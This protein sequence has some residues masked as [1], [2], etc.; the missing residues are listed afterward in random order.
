ASAPMSSAIDAW[1]A[2][3]DKL[4]SRDGWLVDLFARSPELSALADQTGALLP[5]AL[6]TQSSSASGAGISFVVESGSISL[7][8]QPSVLSS[9][10]AK[11]VGGQL[12]AL[13]ASSAVDDK[14]PVGTLSLLTKGERDRVLKEF[15][16]TEIELPYSTVHELFAARVDA[17]PDAVALRFEDESLTYAKL[18]GRANRLAMTL[19]EMGAG[20]DKLLR[21]EDESLTYA[22]LDGRA[23]RLAMTLR[24]MG[25]GPDKLVGVYVER[26]VEMMVSVL[27]VMKAGAAYVPLDPGYPADRIEYMIEHAG[28]CALLV[29]GGAPARMPENAPPVLDVIGIGVKDPLKE[30]A[31]SWATPSSLAY[32]IYTSGS[33]GRPKGVM[34]EHKNAVNFF[35]GMD[36]C[37]PHETPGKWLAVTSL[38]FDI[39]VLELLWTLTRGFEV[40]LFLDLNAGDDERSDRPMDYSLFYWGSDDGEGRQKYKLLLD[41]ARFADEHDFTA[42]WTPERHFHAFGGPYPNPAVTGAAVAAVTKRLQIRSGSCVVPLHHPVR[43]AEEWAVID[44]LS[45]GR[46]ALG[47]A[48]GWQPD[49]FLL[50]PQ[51]YAEVKKRMFEILDDVRKLW[52]GEKM[53]YPGPRGDVEMMSQPR[54]VQKELP[55]WLTT[56]GNPETYRQAAEIDCHVLTHLLGQSVDE[57]AEKV[58]IYRDALEAVGKPR[59]SGKVTLMLH[60]FVGRDT[61]EVRNIV[62]QPMKDYL[63]ASISLVKSYAWAFPAFKRPAGAK[64]AFDLEL[65]GL[66]EEE[67]EAIL[68]FA[69]ERYFEDSGLF[70]DIDKCMQQVERLK[71]IEVDEI[72]CLIDFGVPTDEVLGMLPLLNQ[73]RA[74]SNEFRIARG[75]SYTVSELIEK[76]HVSHMQCT[77]SMARMLAA[78]PA[79]KS[80]LGTVENLFVGGEVFPVDLATDLKANAKGT[81][82][83]MYG[84]TETTIWS[85]TEPVQD[86]LESLPI[87][88]PIANT[89]LYVLNAQHEP[90]PPGVPGDLWIGGEGVVRG[91]LHQPDLTAE[92]FLPDPFVGGDARMYMTGDVARFLD[93]GRVDFIGR[94]DH[95][96]K[97]RGYRVELGEIESRLL[98]HDGVRS[99]AAI[100]RED[101]PGDQRLVAYVVP[102]PGKEPAEAELRAFSRERLPEYMVPQHVV[103]LSAMPQTPNKKIDRKALPA[104]SAASADFA[105]EMVVP[106][107]D[108]EQKVAEVWCHLLGRDNVGI[109]NNFFDLGGHSLLVVQ[110]SMQLQQKLERKIPLVDLYRSPTIRSFV[111][112]LESGG[113]SEQVKKGADRATKRKDAMARRRRGR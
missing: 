3:Q 29:A 38:S 34:I 2:E 89:Q 1:R 79:T 59:D 70:G 75:G 63:G 50:Q 84:P 30:R 19:R 102:Q 103:S 91:Y 58:R 87:G 46:A 49:D 40:V 100:V 61:E 98:E 76:N 112:S 17:A 66:G 80:A 36:A 92:R 6:E 85:S 5:I 48:S 24:E 99:C 33:T 22:E 44:N 39:S 56:A 47:A 42:V 55:I 32:V 7:R 83:N 90:Q 96:V 108:I 62:R 110:L 4:A 64:N 12:S 25:A 51:N 81:V 113:T 67:V 8:H 14:A 106:T 77:P 65:K 37:V 57:V 86:G 41:G 52:R 18:D 21:F 60:T 94:A 97:I 16:Q 111:A 10:D 45:D 107:D 11:R 13:M 54:P 101:S 109:D 95:Q 43:I 74:Q 9:D 26:S 23:N 93:D 35:V 31:A 104:P 69:F 68:D 53:T 71:K 105:V 72:A 15:N 27:G 78:D 73:V 20:P 28:L 82:R 88:R